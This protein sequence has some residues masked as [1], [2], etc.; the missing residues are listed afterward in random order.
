MNSFTMKQLWLFIGAS[1][2]VLLTSNATCDKENRH[3]ASRQYEGTWQYIG[4]SGGIAGFRFKVDTSA[5]LFLQLEDSTY[6]RLSGSNKQ[7]GTYR[8]VSESSR[9]IIKGPYLAFD[10][11]TSGSAL[12]LRNDTLILTQPFADGMSGW[13]IKRDTLLRPCL[14]TSKK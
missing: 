13:Y 6:V 11:A 10:H 3:K 9:A 7:C 2:L 1:A 14:K 5:R 12:R 4:R 8:V